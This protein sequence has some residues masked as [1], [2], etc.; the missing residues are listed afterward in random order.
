[1]Q[2]P[3]TPNENTT[4][5]PVIGLVVNNNQL[6]FPSDT[7]SQQSQASGGGKV[8]LSSP[9]HAK[10]IGVPKTPEQRVMKPVDEAAFAK[11][12]DSDGNRTPWEE[13]NELDFDGPELDEDPIP[14]GQP[15]V[16]SPEPDRQNDAE[17]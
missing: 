13:T 8:S 2:S 14:F 1:M 7:I 3:H 9:L 11:G 6:N 4:L 12:Y 17:K 5:P 16:S 15:P 10:D